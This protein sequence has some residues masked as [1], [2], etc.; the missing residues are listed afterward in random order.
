M[1]GTAAA[2][3]T[4]TMA[5]DFMSTL[6]AVSTNSD[7]YH[8]TPVHMV[9]ARVQSDMPVWSS[10]SDR[11]LSTFADTTDE[12]F[13]A[14]LDTVN[15][16][17]VEGALMYVQAEGINYD[18][19]STEYRCTRKSGMAYIVLY[20]MAI[21]QTNETLA[22]YQDTADQNEYGPLVPMDSGRCTP[23]S[24][25]GSSDVFPT[26][27]YY[28]NGTNG[29]PNIGPFVGAELKE[30]TTDPRAPY[31][32]NVW[33]SFPNSC[34]LESWGDKTDECRATTRHG[35]CD[36]DVMPDGVTCTFNYRVLGFL[37]LDDL[38]GITSMASSTT[39]NTY[40]NFTE[41]CEDGGVEFEATTD[42][43][44]VDGISF[45]LKPQDEDANAERAT[46]L[47]EA[48]SN[49]TTGLLKNTPLQEETIARMLPLPTPA[50]LAAENPP[51][52]LNVKKCNGDYG[53]KRELYSQRCTLC[54]STSDECE[55]APSGWTF[56]TLEKAVG[57][58][59]GTGDVLTESSSSSGSS[60]KTHVST[61]SGLNAGVAAAI[62]TGC[63]FAVLLV[64]FTALPEMAELGVACVS[65]DPEARPR[66]SEALYRLQK[67]LQQF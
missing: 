11:F 49:L 43:E 58:N 37:L 41:F 18:T 53:C 57:E 39:G 35:L 32:N 26:V 29:E 56:P 59:G 3:S 62:V 52:Y 20:E 10:E 6:T 17:S 34:P 8:M 55:T 4:G 65:M 38:V 45:W 33:Y 50:E 2:S 64:L 36:M 22:L 19:R 40:N 15:A 51:C 1:P 12:Q 16:A 30:T 25:D 31:P 9:V 48:Y 47:V 24:T 46:K 7:A 63:I 21:V 44:W 61:D 66:A 28:F 27:C 67:I 60:S 42:G 54:S 14:S 13:I 23:T 5:N